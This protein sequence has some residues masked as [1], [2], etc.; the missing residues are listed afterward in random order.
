MPTWKRP[1]LDTKFY[2]DYKWWIDKGKDVRVA[3]RGQLCADCQAR[4]PDHRNTEAVDWVDPETAEVVRADA[5]LQSLR[6]DCSQK[7]DFISQ[8]NSLVANVFRIFLLNGNQPLT[9]K[10][11]HERIPWQ[12]AEAIL[13]TL[14]SSTVYMGL[15][16]THQ[17]D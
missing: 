16:P 17:N 13:R 6:S 10:E 2:I 4:F 7:A 9:P 1:S 5:L 8:S 15:R 14:A 12:S 3:V 11:L